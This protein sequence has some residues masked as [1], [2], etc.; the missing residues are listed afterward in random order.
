M[1][2]RILP[3]NISPF[4]QDVVQNPTKHSPLV[5]QLS[6]LILES[7]ILAS[8][9]A[10]CPSI[11][12]RASRVAM[13]YVG[14]TGLKYQINDLRKTVELD[15]KLA[16]KNQ[17]AFG[18]YIALARTAQQG[19][20]ILLT[21][22]G[23]AGALLLLANQKQI[24]FRLFDRMKTPGTVSLVISIAL[25]ILK[26]KEASLLLR[27]PSN[28]F[29]PDS[30]RVVRQLD[31]YQWGEFLRSKAISIGRKYLES[32][33]EFTAFDLALRVAFNARTAISRRYP[34]TTF[35]ASTNWLLTLFYTMNAI[36]FD[37]HNSK[38]EVEKNGARGT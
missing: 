13:S 16:Y 25:Q 12:G 18:C 24:A 6:Y 29:S 17:D 9:L 8:Q 7:A 22:G 32:Q 23:T 10:L 15:G 34:N 30:S 35:Q 37:Y 1:L 19:I 2:T 28:D 5:K 27:H 33:K 4:V 20:D 21:V 26:Y 31:A 14:I 38:V 36:R 11:I 3:A